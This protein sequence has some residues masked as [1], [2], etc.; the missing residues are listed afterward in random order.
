[1]TLNLSAHYDTLCNMVIRPPRCQYTEND[2]GP[3]S[4]RIGGLSFVR[5]DFELINVRGLSIKCSHFKPA[6]YWT[7]GKQLPC[8]IYCHGNSGCRLDS[9]E[10][11]RTL[12]PINITVMALDFTGSGLSDGEYV[13]LGY[14]EKEDISTVVK[15][16]RET[17]KISTIGLWGRSMGAVTSILY[18]KEDP[19]IA[20]MVLDSPFCNLYKVAEELVHSNVQKMPKL[21]ISLGLKMIR[22]SIKKRAHFDIKDLDITPTTEQVFIPALFAHGKD[23]DFVKPHHSEK[24]YEK[25][26]GDKNRL[27]LE[28]D[29]N[30]ERPHFF[31][32]SVCIFFVN[33]LKPDPIDVNYNN[34]SKQPQHQQQQIFYED[35]EDLMY[36]EEQLRKAILLSIQEPSFVESQCNQAAESITSHTQTQTQTQ[37][38]THTQTNGHSHN[39]SNGHSQ[40]NNGHSEQVME[41][42]ELPPS[43]ENTSPT[44][45]TTSSTDSPYR[46]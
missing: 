1:M 18:A 39:N 35:E 46:L 24:L 27:L 16:L 7:N 38:E 8:V 22:S 29:H 40:N 34:Q 33:T 19:S 5:N 21:M 42:N 14:Y 13:S 45:S 9:L 11:V 6:E 3:K 10:C 25:Y 4:F 32:E 37:T 26:Q 2:M 17:G 36:E 12:L 43:M 30:S 28:G 20:G 23:D 31:F 15:H 41:R 44:N